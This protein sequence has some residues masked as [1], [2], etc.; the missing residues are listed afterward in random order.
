MVAAHGNL[1]AACVALA[2]WQASASVFRSARAP[3]E[4]GADAAPA[5]LQLGAAP[6]PSPAAAAI[7]AGAA[8]GDAAFP[9][10]APSRNVSLSLYAEGLSFRRTDCSNPPGVTCQCPDPAYPCR[11]AWGDQCFCWTHSTQ[12]WCEGDG[13]HWCERPP[14]CVEHC[15]SCQDAETC[16]VCADGYMQVY[17]LCTLRPPTEEEAWLKAHNLL[18]CVHGSSALAW[19]HA[20]AESAREWADH[21]DS[22]GGLQHSE[23]YSE[24]PP[25]GPAGENLAW[26]H[27]S[28]EAAT[29]D[30]YAEVEC[31]ASL[32]GCQQGS[33]ATGHFTA[34]VWAGV[35][36]LGCA[37]T[38]AHHVCRYRS[39]DS[40]S[41][42]T[43]N[44]G[45]C[46]ERNVLPRSETLGACISMLDSTATTTPAATTTSAATTTT[47]TL[48]VC[49]APQK[50]R[51][52]CDTCIKNSNCANGYSCHNRFKRCVS[53]TGGTRCQTPKAGCPGS[54]RSS[55]CGARGCNCDCEVVGHDG[56]GKDYTWLV[57][58]N[59]AKPNS[60][61]PEA[62][63]VEP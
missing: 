13:G 9:G 57:W 27:G 12:Q 54:C 62:T 2:T 8:T 50:S 23:S 61:A 55:R 14:T 28:P 6:T 58:A 29:T 45:G 21:L 7:A 52:E 31:C 30:W 43:A 53:E 36:E 42:D 49:S 34:M 47:V 22:V 10:P 33:C 44:M 38:G 25:A 26:G 48:P 37:T 63:C 39:G 51:G 11:K 35:A 20:A 32:P 56:E 18:R 15:A 60:R 59:L 46:Y 3:R 4:A 19:S 41:C 24:P 16:A 17:G 40:L 1:A 5:R